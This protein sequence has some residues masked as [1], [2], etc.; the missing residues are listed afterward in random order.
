MLR[1]VSIQIQIILTYIHIIH[2]ESYRHCH[3]FSLTWFC[4]RFYEFWL[5]QT[6]LMLQDTIRMW[7]S[8]LNKILDIWSMSMNRQNSN[9]TKRSAYVVV[10]NSLNFGPKYKII[11]ISKIIWIIII[12]L[13]W[14]SIEFN[15]ISQN[16][17]INNFIQNSEWCEAIGVE[18]GSIHLWI[19]TSQCVVYV[20]ALKNRKFEFIP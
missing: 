20:C 13:L 9:E 17:W 4:Y 6:S 1:P 5:H 15:V 19:S 3:S 8:S 16:I 7:T 2:D 14:N 18:T 12:Y 10:A 11:C